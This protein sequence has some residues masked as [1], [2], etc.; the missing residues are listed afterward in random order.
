MS[1]MDETGEVF[2]KVDDHKRGGIFF[3]SRDQLNKSELLGRPQLVMYTLAALG[4][5]WF[6]V[7]FL[8]A[9]LVLLG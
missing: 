3:S 9:L 5:L 2:S 7:V 6:F 8:I 1:G 4:S